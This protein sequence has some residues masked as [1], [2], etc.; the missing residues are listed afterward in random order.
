MMRTSKKSKCLLAAAALACSLLALPFHATAQTINLHSTD[1]L[2]LMTP[3][4]NLGNTLEAGDSKNNFTPH[5]GVGSETAWQATPTTK[6]V[7]L[8]VKR[9]G[10]RSVR[11]PVAWIMGHVVDSTSCVIDRQWMDRVQQVVDYCIDNDMYVVLNDHWDGGWLENSFKKDISETAI[12]RNSHILKTLW[13]QIA[14]RFRDYD[15]HLLFAGLN[16]PEVE[17]TE[18][19]AALSRYEQAFIDA[20]RET[21]GNN[22]QRVLIIQAPV[23][24]IDK[25]E[26]LMKRL[27][28][29]TTEGKLMVEV[30]YYTPYQFTLMN[31]DADWGKRTF[32]WGKDNHKEGSAY[33]AT[34]GEEDFVRKQFLKMKT[35]FV[36]KGYP[37]LLGE[38]GTNWRDVGKDGE[39]QVKHDA[40]V[41]AWYACVTAEAVRC[42]MIPMIWDTN[43]PEMGSMTLIDREKLSLHCTVAYEGIR[44]GL[45]AVGMRK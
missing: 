44:E 16:E 41:K 5:A 28:V 12:T 38:Y 30:H 7:I 18:Q 45:K 40:S 20:V 4:W 24:D 6:E 8:Y 14:N 11:L 17:N 21:G 3:G 26:A 15:G 33:N 39:D 27:P 19:M 34:W 1:M 25:A 9:M 32:Y 31:E 29:D 43:Y 22:A 37:V 23:T 13:T 10:F 2:P 36:D 35:L 42:G